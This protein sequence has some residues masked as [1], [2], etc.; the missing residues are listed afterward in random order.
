MAQKPHT[1]H[2]RRAAY[3]RLSYSQNIFNVI[4]QLIFVV[5]F[6]FIMYKFNIRYCYIS[7]TSLDDEK[8]VQSIILAGLRVHGV[9]SY[10]LPYN[11]LNIKCYR[12]M[13]L[14]L[15]TMLLNVFVTVHK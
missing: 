13:D 3:M 6:I 9:M 5:N 10:V 12:A 11:I 14:R 4:Y 2:V 15:T 8:G 1:E 7:S